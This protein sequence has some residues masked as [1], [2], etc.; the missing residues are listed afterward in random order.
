VSPPIVA[1]SL[2]DPTVQAGS[3]G[4]GGPLGR[5]ARVGSTWWTPL[6][7]LI[8]LCGLGYA[9]GYL[10]D[11]SCRSDNWASP[12]RYE[13]LCYSDIPPLYSLRGFAD[14][15]IPYLQSKPGEM[16][17][18]YPVITGAFMQVAA[19]FTGG[20]VR[21][22][23]GLDAAVVF[24]DV[25]VAMLFIPLVIAVIATALTVRRRPWDA[26]MVALAPTVVMAATINWDM[27][28]LA[29]AGVALLLWSRRYPFAA[30]LA[31][32]LAIAS[33]FYPLFFLGAFLVLTIRTGKWR[34]FGVFLGGTALAWIVVNLPVAL[35]S[36]DG[37]SFFYRFSQDRGE[38]FGSPWFA[39]SQYGLNGVPADAINAVSSGAFLALCVG[40]AA[41][42]LLAPR[43]PRL[44][45]VLFLIIAAFV[46]TNK[47][48]SPQYV[49]WLV[50]LA[51]LARPRW[52]DFLIW[53][54]GELLYFAAIWWFLVGY[55]IED[56]KG[57]TPQWYATATLVHIAATVY[58]AAMIVRDILRPE[59][60]PIRTDG[61]AEDQDDPGGG[62]FDGAP[63]VVGPARRLSRDANR[64]TEQ[65][66][67][68]GS[69]QAEHRVES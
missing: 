30:G 62:V 48:Y 55:G 34:A 15:L 17:L 23:S 56:T 54:A 3:Y 39:I 59:H 31:L 20:I 5:W 61:F 40:I 12:Q 9:L 41:L 1:P 26:A 21:I 52:R 19:L 49:L 69:I 4:I 10:L 44:A 60:D 13:H 42:A 7:V 65:A 64:S 6:R 22:Q 47:V 51:A 28:P 33:K 8:G 29:F 50:P 53:Q 38:D 67:P 18:E 46:I 24:F 16:P 57:L 32:G 37:W 14:G 25:N 35:A 45:Q 36:F 66:S 63:D 2:Q 27:L 11:L 68:Q 43:R 58:F